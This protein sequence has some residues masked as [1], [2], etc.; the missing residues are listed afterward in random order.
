MLF[1]KKKKKMWA[2]YKR[3]V[4][5]LQAILNI[6]LTVKYNNRLHFANWSLA[7]HCQQA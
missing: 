3:Q 5:M 7:V 2:W 4:I 1:I 6:D